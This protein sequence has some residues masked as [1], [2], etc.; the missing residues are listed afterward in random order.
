MKIAIVGTGAMGCIYAALLADAGHE[1][2]AIDVNEAHVTAMQTKG[3]RVEG[4]SGDRVVKVNATTKVADAG[5]CD[6]VIIAT[7]GMHVAAACKSATS[8]IG[9]DSMVLS[10]QNGLGG[11][12]IAAS[13]LGEDRVMVGVVG[14]FGASMVGPGHA[15][16]AGME[17]VRLGERVGPV[18]PRLETVAETWRSGGFKVKCFDDIDQLI[19]EKL[20]CNVGLSGPCGITGY[21]VG[22]L[23][24]DADAFGLTAA[25]VTEAFAVAKGRKIKLDFD[26][27]VAY[28]RNFASKIPN[29]KPSLLQDIEAGR[30]S[31]IDVINGAIPPAAEA[32][33]LSAPVN[34]T[35]SRAIRVRE[36]RAGLR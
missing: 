21:S 5:V 18:T 2:W 30:M 19:W 33:G 23:L 34:T 29:S 28:V 15:R 32:L 7:K 10:I 20:I 16:H 25:A 35:L 12:D 4:A 17:L 22:E 31:E 36:R 24:E 3:L 27:P 11:P 9:P 13:L 26:D 14:G 6:L 1:I 8:L